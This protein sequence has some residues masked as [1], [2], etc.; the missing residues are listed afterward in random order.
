M[1]RIVTTTYRYKRPPRKRKPVAIEVPMVV[2][3]ADP[4]KTRR[5]AKPDS[6]A[7]NDTDAAP[8]PPA[9]D[10]RTSRIVTTRRGKGK[11]YDDLYD[12][13]DEEV[14][15]RGDAADELFRELVRRSTKKDQRDT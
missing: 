12:M 14:R 8:A 9:T 13:T 10:D 15:R 11:R 3:A 5:V 2:K 1:T 6:T 4:A 7:R